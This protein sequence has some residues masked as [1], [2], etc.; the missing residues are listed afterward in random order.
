MDRIR[1]RSGAK[2]VLATGIAAAVLAVASPAGAAA[3]TTTTIG[4]V[5]ID[6]TV[7]DPGLDGL[8]GTRLQFTLLTARTLDV[9]CGANGQVAMNG[10]A[11]ATPC[12]DLRIGVGVT[13]SGYSDTV[14]VDARNLPVAPQD[15]TITLDLGYGHDKGTV[16]HGDATARLLGGGGNDTLTVGMYGDPWRSGEFAHDTLDGGTGNDTLTNRG[17]VTPNTQGD[18]SQV[19]LEG[20]SLIGGAGADRIWGSATRA[21]DVVADLADA[22][23]FS[24]GPGTFTFVGGSGAETVS[25]RANGN[26]GPLVRVIAGSVTKDYALPTPTSYLALQTGAGNDVVTVEHKSVRTRIS[27]QPG[28]GTDRVTIR[29]RNPFTWDQAN[30]VVSQPGASLITYDKPATES[31]TVKAL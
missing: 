18:P 23:S 6:T 21:D 27:A 25:V 7:F 13:G 15:G 11:L 14:T 17:Y 2:A 30:G 28:T 3:T 1:I 19:S 5:R 29:P 31:I 24:G 8:S 12:A 20:V 4:G 10:T 16:L 9:R 22:V 26:H